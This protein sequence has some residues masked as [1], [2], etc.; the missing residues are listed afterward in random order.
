MVLIKSMNYSGF[1]YITDIF[2]PLDLERQSYSKY[3]IAR[4]LFERYMG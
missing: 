1:K 3:M 4:G 2:A